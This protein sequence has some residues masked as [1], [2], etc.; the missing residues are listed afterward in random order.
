MKNARFPQNH[1]HDP[2]PCPDR[3]TQI[4]NLKI[5]Y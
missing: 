3:K 5:I 2:S 1:A 4:K